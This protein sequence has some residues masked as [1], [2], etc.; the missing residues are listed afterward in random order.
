MFVGCRRRQLLEDAGSDGAALRRFLTG[1]APAGKLGRARLE[2]LLAAMQKAGPVDA[3]ARKQVRALQALPEKARAIAARAA[4]DLG[5]ILDDLPDASLAAD[6][7]YLCRQIAG[8]LGR[9]PAE[10]LAALARVRG[11][12]IRAGHARAFVASS[13]ATET[14]LIPDLTALLGKLEQP[15]A[16]QRM[17]RW[18]LPPTVWPPL[19]KQRAVCSGRCVVSM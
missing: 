9:P 10:T 6:F 5:E 17:W 13:P 4:G 3:A 11:L 8:D 15:V 2:K 16:T 1:L 14:S 18:M 19:C 7:A 12:L